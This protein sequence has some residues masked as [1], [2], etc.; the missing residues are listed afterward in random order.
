[1]RGLF[2]TNI[3]LWIVAA[4]LYPLSDLVTAESGEPPKF[5]SVLIPLVFLML[6]CASTAMIGK[7][8]KDPGKR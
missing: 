4:L 6:A 8:S 7:A 3:L 1:M 2:V 5:F